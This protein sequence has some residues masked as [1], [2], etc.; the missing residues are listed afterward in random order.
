MMAKKKSK[1][2]RPDEVTERVR[3]LLMNARKQ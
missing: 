3:H 2:D 1:R